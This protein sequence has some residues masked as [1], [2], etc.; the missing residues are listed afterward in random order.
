MASGH[1]PTH[2]HLCY[3]T[4]AEGKYASKPEGW[5]RGGGGVIFK[6]R[7]SQY[8]EAGYSYLPNI[9][10]LY[11]SEFLTIWDKVCGWLSRGWVGGG[12]G[13]WV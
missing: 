8:S 3:H 6:G 13:G 4:A 5:E 7:G 12:G 2:I 9:K 10:D 1:T 11:S